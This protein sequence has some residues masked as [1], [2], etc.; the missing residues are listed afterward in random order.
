MPRRLAASGGKAAAADE[1]ET[2][3]RVNA[4]NRFSFMAGTAAAAVTGV[5]GSNFSLFAGCSAAVYQPT[6]QVLR[7][8]RPPASLP[9]RW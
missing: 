1:S 8:P 9:V 2:A 5:F 4:R 6:S 7:L 3:A